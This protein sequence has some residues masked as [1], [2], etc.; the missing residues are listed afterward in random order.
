MGITDKFGQM[1]DSVQN[2]AKT[3]STSVVLLALKGATA[4][5]VALTL[6]MVGQELINY[7][8]LSFIMVL[9]VV[10]FG[11]GKILSSWSVGSVLVFDLICVLVAL[12]LR[13]YVLIAP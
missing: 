1:V 9:V 5:I 10:S 2:G 11:I 8:T 7:G 4:F 12:L 6:A 3:A 13:M